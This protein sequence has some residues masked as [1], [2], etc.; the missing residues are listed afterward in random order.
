MDYSSLIN[1][2][3]ITVIYSTFIAPNLKKLGETKDDISRTKMPIK[4]HGPGEDVKNSIIEAGIELNEKQT[5]YRSKF[6]DTISFLKIFSLIVVILIAAQIFVT[7]YLQKHSLT[8]TIYIAVAI[9]III[10]LSYALKIYMTA[11]WNTRSL[12][13]LAERGVTTAYYDDLFDPMLECNPPLSNVEPDHTSLKILLTANSL[14]V[15]FSYVLI[16]ESSDSS[17]IYYIA[18]GPVTHYFES[19]SII[20]NISG[21][22]RSTITLAQDIALKPGKYSVRLLILQA[23]FP[24][25]YQ[26]SETHQNI[27]I[28]SSGIEC[29]PTRIDLNHTSNYNFKLDESDKILD[30][31]YEDKDTPPLSIRYLFSSKNF[32][33]CLRS[34]KFLYYIFDNSGTISK[35]DIDRF[36]SWSNVRKQRFKRFFHRYKNRPKYLKLS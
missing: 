26:V 6:W 19:A 4:N 23:P 17:R 22:R 35:A 8:S 16:I 32:E 29:K 21:H 36:Y 3:L 13:W 31:Q 20:N 14:F 28:T 9:L 34:G 33:K 2:A 11:P 10:L 27:D 25:S 7:F 24:G 12:R 1:I 15:G 30:L 18:S 5:Q